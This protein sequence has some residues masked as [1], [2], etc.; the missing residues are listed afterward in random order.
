MLTRERMAPMAQKMEPVTRIFW[1]EKER[2]TGSASWKDS[3]YPYAESSSERKRAEREIPAIMPRFLRVAL[4]LDARDTLSR[5]RDRMISV[6]F[7]ARKSDMPRERGTKRA[8]ISA[9]SLTRTAKLKRKSEAPAMPMP[10]AGSVLAFRL[11]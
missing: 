11:S 7:G 2:I 4:M 6:A 1:M 5:G 10:H 3:E 9:I 8:I